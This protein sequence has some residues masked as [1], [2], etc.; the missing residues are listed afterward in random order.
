MKRKLYLWILFGVV[1]TLSASEVF[2][3]LPSH[4]AFEHVH[5][6]ALT[7]GGQTLFLGA[8]TGLFKSDDGGRTWNNV[9]LPAK[10][11]HL[12]VMSVTL[13]PTDP[14]TIYVGTHEAGVLKSADGGESWKE[15]NG[16]LGGSDV[17]GLAIDPNVPS[18]LH[19]A[20]R[21]KGEGIYRTT[22]GGGKWVRVDDGPGGEVKILASVNIATG[23]GGIFLYAGTA[24][25]LFRSPDCF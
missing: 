17:H 3:P 25:G 11:S 9:A 5:A 1:W 6:L 13:D 23:M 16:G 22:D 12:D 14:R 2:D 18:K 20:V 4:A 19:A 21:D 7:P 24:A 15:M 10:G 8:H